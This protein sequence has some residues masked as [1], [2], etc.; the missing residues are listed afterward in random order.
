MRLEHIYHPTTD[1]LIDVKYHRN[2]VRQPEA[3]IITLK[4][5]VYRIA[6]QATNIYSRFR[7]EFFD[8]NTDI[9]VW[10]HARIKSLQ[11]LAIPGTTE[12]ALAKSLI[13]TEYKNFRKSII[14]YKLF[15]AAYLYYYI[16]TI[17]DYDLYNISRN[18]REF[19]YILSC[20]TNMQ[21]EAYTSFPASSPKG[22][23]LRPSPLG[24]YCNPAHLK[25]DPDHRTKFDA[26]H[27]DFKHILLFMSERAIQIHDI[28]RQLE[29][30]IEP[31]MGHSIGS[32]RAPVGGKRRCTR[33]NRRS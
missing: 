11:P 22:T 3:T 16:T 21:E 31:A 9:N 10:G 8:M 1:L 26:Y 4:R 14:D 19:L 6:F 7:T 12:Y 33:R 15:V 28:N 23:G 17:S 2:A 30:F 29:S 32:I 27:D 24:S 25:Y 20:A 5:L 13:Q 18:S